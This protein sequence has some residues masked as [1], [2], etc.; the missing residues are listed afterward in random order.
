MPGIYRW[1]MRRRICRWYAQLPQ[2]DRAADQSPVQ[3]RLRRLDA[4]ES[5]SVRLL[6]PAAFGL[7]AYLLRERA[8]SH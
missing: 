4:L 7:E 2:F 6:V 5:R 3:A 8:S 1:A